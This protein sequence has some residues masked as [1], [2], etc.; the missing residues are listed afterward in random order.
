MDRLRERANKRW[1]PP[2][3]EETTINENETDNVPRKMGVMQTNQI[4]Q[5]GQDVVAGVGEGNCK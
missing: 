5:T 3:I 1:P 4:A 2:P